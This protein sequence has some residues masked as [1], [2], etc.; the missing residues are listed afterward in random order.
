M[1]NNSIY[2]SE[3]QLITPQPYMTQQAVQIN[4]QVNG[5]AQQV[6]QEPTQDLEAYD[7]EENQE[8]FMGEDVWEWFTATFLPSW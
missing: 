3:D 1:D 4:N 5:A 6:R 8:V 2:K 7:D